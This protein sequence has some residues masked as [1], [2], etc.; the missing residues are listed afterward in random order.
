MIKV[1]M[2]ENN[3]SDENLLQRD[4]RNGREEIKAQDNNRATIENAG[5][6]KEQERKVKASKY[7]QANADKRKAYGAAYRKANLNKIKTRSVEYYQSNAEKF[8]AYSAAYYQFNADTCKASRVTFRKANPEKSRASNQ[9]RSARERGAIVIADK[10]AI[11]AWMKSIR[12][13]PTVTC[14]WCLSSFKSSR[15]HID[16]IN[17]LSKGGEHSLA[18]LCVS[19]PKCNLTKQAKTLKSWNASLEQPVLF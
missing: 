10:K 3:K 8:K 19:C 7:Y 6:E 13:K 11:T 12:L 9:L 17:S 18:N 2:Y 15:I 16:H 14:Y 1:T 5:S 4:G